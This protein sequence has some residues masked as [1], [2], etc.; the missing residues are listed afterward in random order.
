MR[1]VEKIITR[2]TAGVLSKGLYEINGKLYYVKG[3]TE[4]NREPF[5]EVIGSRI[6]NAFSGLP[7]VLYNIGSKEYFKDIKS[8][9]EYVSLCEK[10]PFTMHRFYEYGSLVASNLGLRFG[11]D[12][13]LLYKRLGLFEEFLLRMLI[14][15]AW[16]GNQ[17][18][19][20]NNFDVANNNGVL[21]NAPVLDFGASLLYNVR[22]MD[23]KEKL[24]IGPDKS[25]PL[26][27][28]HQRQIQYLKR[29]YGTPKLFNI[30]KDRAI[31]QIWDGNQDIFNLMSKK[32]AHCIMRYLSN[33]FD[34]YVK[35][36]CF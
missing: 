3:A 15:D 2:T 9:F 23:L 1:L 4:G 14:F 8:D 27:E 28:T 21:V 36:F 24:R 32:R 25:K 18:R 13:L 17:D 31:Q 20:L 7:T 30:S 12:Y 16:I 26:K 35:D 22:E 10:V 34:V 11:N 6:F 19:H 29:L 33:R 5:S